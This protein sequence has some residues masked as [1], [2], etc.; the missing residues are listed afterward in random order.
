V[1]IKIHAADLQPILQPG[2]R[3]VEQP[4]ACQKDRR[5]SSKHRQIAM[6]LKKTW[7]IMRH[8]GISWDILPNV[9]T[10]WKHPWFVPLNKHPY[11]SSSHGLRSRAALEPSMKY[12]WCPTP[13]LVKMVSMC[14]V[15]SWPH[16]G[17][18]DGSQTC[19]NPI[20]PMV[21]VNK[22]SEYG[23]KEWRFGV[24]SRFLELQ[25]KQLWFCEERWPTN[26]FL[27]RANVRA[28]AA[29]AW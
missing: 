25:L 5:S 15:G 27:H 16:Q 29:P 3:A 9:E 14:R 11:T 22:Y 18:S 20:Y 13:P 7:D 4:P 10:S 8:H 23:H 1:H 24:P 2:V 28:S 21:K 19:G 6:F 12:I 17:M 26:S